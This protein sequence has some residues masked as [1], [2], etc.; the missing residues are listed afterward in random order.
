MTPP[1][2]VRFGHALAERWKPMCL[3]AV[4]LCAGVSA[5]LYMWATHGDPFLAA[6]LERTGLIT[7]GPVVDIEKLARPDGTPEWRVTYEFL[8]VPGDKFR[9][10]IRLASH[11]LVKPYEKVGNVTVRYLPTEPRINAIVGQTLTTMTEDLGQ[12]LILGTGAGV[13]PLF[14][15]LVAAAL[16]ARSAASSSP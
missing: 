7:E 12:A 4:W 15:A 14:Y 8:N 2:P 6:K 5:C 10:S 3:A 9:G 11:D 1:Y 16:K 13:L